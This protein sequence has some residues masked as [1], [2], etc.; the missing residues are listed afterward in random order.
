MK[1]NNMPTLGAALDY[2]RLSAVLYKDAA[3]AKQYPEGLEL[4]YRLIDMARHAEAMEEELT[5]ERA[6]LE[7]LR[8]QVEEATHREQEA[9]GLYESALGALADERAKQQVE[10]SLQSAGIIED[11]DVDGGLIG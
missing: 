7:K 4:H 6:E 5:G 3:T 2:A 9:M 8:E 11:P 1:S 10:T